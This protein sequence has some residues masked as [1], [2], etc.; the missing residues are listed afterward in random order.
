VEDGAS[1]ALEQGGHMNK[2]DTLSGGIKI[3]YLTGLLKLFK[4]DLLKARL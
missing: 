4:P 3:S 2:L 1:Y